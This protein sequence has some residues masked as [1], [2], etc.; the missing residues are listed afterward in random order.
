[1]AEC[2]G[3]HA[4]EQCLEAIEIAGERMGANV[5]LEVSLELLFFTLKDKLSGKNRMEDF[6]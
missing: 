4:L 3:Y 5:N 6:S 1:M 2:F